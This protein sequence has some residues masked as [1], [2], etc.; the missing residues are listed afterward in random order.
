[1]IPLLKEEVLKSYG[2]KSMKIV[3]KNNQAIDHTL[4]LL[5]RVEIPKHWQSLELPSKKEET[6]SRYVKEIF[7]PINAQEGNQLSVGTLVANQMTTGE[8]PLGTAALEK[9]GVAL[10]VPEWISDRCTM[11]NECA[12]VCPHAAIRPFLAD[13]EELTEAPEGFIVRDMRGPDGL[14]YRI[15]VSVEDCTG[16]G[17]CVEACPAKGKALVMKP[18]EEQKEQAVNWAFAMTLRQKENPMK[19]K[20][21]VM[22]TQF[23]QPLLEFSGACS[24]CGETPYVKLLTQMF[25]D[26]MMIANATGCSSIWGGASPAS[27]FTTNACG[28]GPA[29]SNSLLEDNAEFGYGMLLAAQTRREALAQSVREIMPKVS[30]ALRLLMEDWLNH[31]FDSEGTQQRAAK[32]QAAMVAEVQQVPELES[33]LEHKDIFVKNSQW[34]IGGDGWAYDIGFGGID[35]VLASGADVNILVLDNEVYSNTGANL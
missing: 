18:Y 17:L 2:H 25:G 26:R 20:N 23:N 30:S 12:F 21:T 10:E 16:C 35:H 34:I 27:P 24:G 19:G 5:H 28:Q 22:A 1:M 15:Q 7:T 13:E 29:W 33:I 6:T 9:R 32:L 11:C 8:M 3:E 4:E 14:K 31:L